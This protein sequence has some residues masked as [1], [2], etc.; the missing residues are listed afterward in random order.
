MQHF[1]A[2]HFAAF[3]FAANQLRGLAQEIV[4]WGKTGGLGKKKKRHITQSARA[5]LKEY[6]ATVFN[7]P[8]AKDLK[9]EVK[10][11]IKP[12]L[13]ISSIDYAQL[14]ENIALVE[15]IIARYQEYKQEQEDEEIFL[16]LI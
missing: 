1:K 11:Y 2:N 15:R 3:H 10:E 14:Y 12:G 6:L 5:E 7:E 8:I 4:T 9:E 13:S 16:M